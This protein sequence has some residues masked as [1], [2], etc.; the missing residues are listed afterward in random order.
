MITAG[1]DKLE[2][3]VQVSADVKKLRHVLMHR[4]DSGIEKVTPGR[5]VDLLYEDIVYLPRMIEEHDLLSTLITKLSS[6]NTV[7]EFQK[8]LQDILDIPAVRHELLYT[9]CKIEGA[10]ERIAQQME[11]MPSE[12][13]ASALITGSLEWKKRILLFPPLPNL[14]FCRDLGAIAE[15][16]LIVGQAALKAR[17]RET[18]LSWFIFRHH[19]FFEKQQQ[20]KLLFSL[21]HNSD[22]LIKQN[23]ER[24]GLYGLEG[25]DLMMLAPGHLLIGSSER[26]TPEAIQKLIQFIRSKNSIQRISVVNM[27]HVR[28]YMHLDTIFTPIDQNECV[29]FEPLVSKENKMVIHHYEAGSEKY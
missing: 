29:G 10:E 5:A 1:I 8:L 6:D 11:T 22:E 3:K 24:F 7:L 14:I 9:V 4:P 15:D 16:L 21:A 25:G 13:V 18:I 26:S 19:P 28:S 17:R 20:Q 23:T 12:Q 2:H 27:P